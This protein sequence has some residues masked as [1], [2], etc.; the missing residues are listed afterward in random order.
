MSYEYLI[1]SYFLRHFYME[2]WLEYKQSY[3]DHKIIVH[4]LNNNLLLFIIEQIS[5]MYMG[6]MEE[7][8]DQLITSRHVFSATSSNT[9]V[10]G[11]YCKTS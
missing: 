10:E 1:I 8:N 4:V 9:K 3:W 5:M 7:M 2:P 11:P 6:S